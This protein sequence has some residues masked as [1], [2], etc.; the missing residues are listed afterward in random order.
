MKNLLILSYYYPPLG[1]SGVQRTVKFV[2]YLPQFGWNPIVIAPRP[3]G[4]YIYDPALGA[5]VAQA[6]VFRTWSLDP[7]FLSPQKNTGSAIHKN[8]LA[9]RINRWLLPDNKTGWIP[10]ALQ[11]GM[12]A[13]RQFPIDA[14]YSTAPPYSSHLAG[15]L[16]KKFLDRPL[17]ADFRDAWTS[18]TWTKYPAGPLRKLDHKMEELVL[19]NADLVT[20]VNSRILDDLCG[21]HPRIDGSK[22][23]LVSHGY[24]PEDFA[25][26]SSPDPDHFTIAYTGTFINNRSPRTLFEAVKLLRKQN[27]SGL[28]KLR[29]V[30]AGSHRES[31]LAL[32]K[33][34]ELNSIVRFTGYLTH[35]QSI[36]ILTEANLL[37]LTMGPE[38]TANVTPGKLFEYLGS[39]KPIAAS[40]PSNGAAAKI[41]IGAGAGSVVAPDDTSG[42]AGIIRQQM[43][44]WENKKTASPIDPE[45]L[46]FFD[47]RLITQQFSDLLNGLS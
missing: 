35:R 5:E 27:F 39:Q 15:V 17:V 6:K 43:S 31:D 47:R 26:A 36:K 9:S 1:L 2:K 21:L 18:Y 4:S 14:I 7:L 44:A 41:V 30:F 13:A 10:F 42:L 24:D 37:W 20:A 3:R 11:A 45:R 23:H 32:V 16:L 8:S 38:E 25:G 40:I 19:K 28:N 33:E 46:K 12:K 22:F 29:I 34:F